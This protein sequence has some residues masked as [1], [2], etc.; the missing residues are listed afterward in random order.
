MNNSIGLKSYEKNNLLGYRQ[1]IVCR[2][3]VN[4]LAYN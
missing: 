2:T 1:L 4:K 3:E